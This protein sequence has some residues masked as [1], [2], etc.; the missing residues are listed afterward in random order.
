MGE[1]V[2]AAA[3]DGE[4]LAGD[5]TGLAGDEEGYGVGDVFWLADAA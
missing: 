1:E 2:G 5:E 3:V 4:D